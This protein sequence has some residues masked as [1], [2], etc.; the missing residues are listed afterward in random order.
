M[1]IRTHNVL[2]PY[3]QL[4]EFYIYLYE[5]SIFCNDFYIVK[6]TKTWNTNDLT[7]SHC[8]ILKFSYVHKPY[9]YS[10]KNTPKIAFEESPS[11]VLAAQLL[12]RQPP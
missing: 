4:Y 1:L 9:F 7:H 10:M 6:Y 2:H 5:N 12:I 3:C 8:Q 11:L